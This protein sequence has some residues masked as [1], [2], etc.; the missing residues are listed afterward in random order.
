ML[1]FYQH[2]YRRLNHI[3]P[4]QVDCGELCQKACC[5]PDLGHGVY[6]FPGEAQMFQTQADW[7]TLEDFNGCQ[8]LNCTGDCP[9]RERPLFC[10]LFPLWPYL[11][12]SGELSLQFYA[13]MACFC[14]LIQ[15]KDFSILAPDYLAEVQ[16]IA[17]LLVQQPACRDFLDRLAREIDAYLT[18][19]PWTKLF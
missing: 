13:P 11:S 2:L 14:P 18:G 7:R 1:K 10:R 4:L 16:K 12:A 8:V 17:T 15:L 9:R 5:R 19:E 6:L 3:T